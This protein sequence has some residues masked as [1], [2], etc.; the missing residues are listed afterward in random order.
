MTTA[1]NH[2]SDSE[3]TNNEILGSTFDPFSSAA[4]LRAYVECNR[5]VQEIVLEM[6]SI[7]AD[8]TSTPDESQIAFDAMIQAL[9]PGI[10]HDVL[11][12][13]QDAFKSEEA[14]KVAAE[15]HLE[16]RG[17]SKRVRELMTKKDVTQD[18]L[19]KAAGISQSAVANILAR[20]CRPQRRTVV[21][22]AE[23]LGVQPKDLWPSFE[24]PQ[25]N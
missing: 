16:E 2:N 18:E 6:A 23:A 24:E 17:F 7:V 4:L 25:V 10:A 14:A 3:T 20:S 21:K 13:S 19:G 8:K 9:F 15:Q 5:E 12:R 11:E 1:A 22:F